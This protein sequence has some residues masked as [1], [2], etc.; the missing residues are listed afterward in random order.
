MLFGIGIPKAM[1]KTQAPEYQFFIKNMTIFNCPQITQQCSLPNTWQ[2][3][4]PIRLY[5]FNKR[6]NSI[7]LLLLDLG[8]YTA[9][10][11]M[12]VWR[13]IFVSGLYFLI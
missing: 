1:P 5:F 10:S 13:T 8:E 12:S 2:F 9:P 4:Y 7:D 11:S 3:F 6:W